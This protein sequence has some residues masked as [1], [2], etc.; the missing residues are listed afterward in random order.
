MGLGSL[1]PS[2]SGFETYVDEIL[3]SKGGWNS[4]RNASGTMSG[5]CS[6]RKCS[7]SSRRR[8]AG[9]FPCPRKGS[10]TVSKQ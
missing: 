5:R 2:H 6:E 9:Y 7:R 1:E 10:K 8:T 4:G 3:L